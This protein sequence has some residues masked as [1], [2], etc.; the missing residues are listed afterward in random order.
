LEL[1]ITSPTTKK[2]WKTVNRGHK[3]P[4]S[5]NHTLYY[6]IP[7]IINQYEPLRNWG[8]YE[9]MARESMKTHELKVRNEG[10]VKLQRKTNIKL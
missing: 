3:K 9:K 5:V 4:P 6:Q 7:V 8:N 1:N 10:R 2:P